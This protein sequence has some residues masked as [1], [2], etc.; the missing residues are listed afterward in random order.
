MQRLG[1]FCNGTK[2]YDMVVVDPPRLQRIKLDASPG[3][4]ARAWRRLF[5]C[6]LWRHVP[7]AGYF[8][9]ILVFAP[10]EYMLM[11]EQM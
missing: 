4:E 5:L 3:L 1:T 11:L 9:A 10:R 7:G 6:H 2:Y 8:C